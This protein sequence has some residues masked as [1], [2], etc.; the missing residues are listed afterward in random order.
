MFYNVKEKS[1]SYS[2]TVSGMMA[3][4][5][6]EE[7]EPIAMQVGLLKYNSDNLTTKSLS[8][9]GKSS[10]KLREGLV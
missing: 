3:A 2:L 6:L 4:S 1:F 5:E 9:T 10:R 7:Q 8:V